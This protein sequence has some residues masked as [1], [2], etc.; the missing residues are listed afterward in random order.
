M[1]RRNLCLMPSVW[2]MLICLFAVSAKAHFVWLA[3]PLSS[4]QVAN[5]PTAEPIQIYFA[6]S[7]EPGDADLLE[8]IAAIQAW[9]VDTQQ[10]VTPLKVNRSAT[11][12]TI[13]LGDD[14]TPQVDVLYVASLAYGVMQREGEPYRLVYVAKTGPSRVT[15]FGTSHCLRIWF[16][17]MCNSSWSVEPWY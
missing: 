8:R 6:E 16:H 11:E 2:G 7:P 12:M 17:W 9:R 1:N 14:K 5:Q 10:Q 4:S 13:G 3:P 15:S